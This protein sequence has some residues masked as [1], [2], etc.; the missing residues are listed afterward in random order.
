VFTENPLIDNN[1]AS[2][3]VKLGL[4]RFNTWASLILGRTAAENDGQR[5]YARIFQGLITAVAGRGVSVIAALLSVPLTVGYLG[6]ERY[7]VWM[8]ISTLLA[9]LTLADF[10]VGNSLTNALSETFVADQRKLAQTHVASVFWLLCAAALA[11]AGLAACVWRWVDWSGLLNVQTPSVAADLGPAV[12]VTLAIFLLNFPLSIISRILSAYQESAIANFW[13]AGGSIASLGGLV[14]ATHFKVGLVPLIGAYSAS[15]L[16]VTAASAVWLFGFY[17]PWL[18][19]SISA[20]DRTSLGKLMNVGGMFFV[21]QIAALLILQTDNLVIAHFL[22]AQ[23]VTPYSVTWRLFSFSTLLQTLLLQSLWPAYAEAY[24][25]GDGAWIRRTFRTSL[26][27]CFAVTLGMVVPLVLFGNQII[28]RWAG[29]EAVPSFTLLVL[30]GVWSLVGGAF[31]SIVCM[32]NGMG[33]V[34]IQMTVGMVTSIAN[35]AVSVW[36]VRWMGVEGVI[37]GTLISYLIFA[38][39]PICFA[40]KSALSSLA[41]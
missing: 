10:G 7:G 16:L 13:M 1:S 3:M 18:R 30:M 26:L 32:L 39:I 17:K 34:K 36:L 6:S 28:H 23:A 35:I 41:R 20:V 9:W 19:P 11:L 38:V 2:I 25:R 37:L 15:S 33:R 24:A 22:G 4:N 12:A 14:L 5:R 21:A 29:P 8:T 27:S 40:T 31:Q